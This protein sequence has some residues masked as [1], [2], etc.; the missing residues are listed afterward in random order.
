MMA[1]IIVPPAREQEQYRKSLFNHQV[2]RLIATLQREGVGDSSLTAT[3]ALCGTLTSQPAA[4]VTFTLT[5][6]KFEGF[7][8]KYQK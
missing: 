3:A 7:P 1:D 2:T 4:K 5:T 6:L 8:E